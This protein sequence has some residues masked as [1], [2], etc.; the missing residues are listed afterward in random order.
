MTDNQSVVFN[1]LMRLKYN[2]I[3][4]NHVQTGV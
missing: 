3:R 1:Y 2:D 4:R